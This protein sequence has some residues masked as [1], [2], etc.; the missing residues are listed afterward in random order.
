ME[1]KGY[2]ANAPRPDLYPQFPG[3]PGTIT[4][5]PD[6]SKPPPYDQT[7]YPPHHHIYKR[8]QLKHENLNE[9]HECNVIFTGYKFAA[10]SEARLC[11]CANRDVNVGHARV[12]C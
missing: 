2:D 6:Y 8:L 12:D 11:S 9:Y 4:N 10:V 7:S 5:Q 1:S 3:G